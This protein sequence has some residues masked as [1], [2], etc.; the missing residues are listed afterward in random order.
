MIVSPMVG[1][2]AEMGM[3]ELEVVVVMMEEDWVIESG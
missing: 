1:N 2:R 3:L